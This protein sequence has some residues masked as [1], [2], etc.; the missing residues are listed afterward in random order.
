LR[1]SDHQQNRGNDRER[2]TRHRQNPPD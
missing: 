2:A 1:L